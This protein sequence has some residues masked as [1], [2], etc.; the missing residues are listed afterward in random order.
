MIG[1]PPR[2][3]PFPSTTLSRSGLLG[4]GSQRSGFGCRFLRP[5][6]DTSRSEE[7]TSELQSRVDISYAVFCLKQKSTRM[8]PVTS[9]YLVCRLLL[10]EKR[11]TSH[12]AVQRE[13]RV[14]YVYSV[15]FSVF[16]LFFFFLKNG[17][18]PEF[19]FFPPQ[20]PFPI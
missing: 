1:R 7:H 5:G 2:S 13:P 8:N 16:F 18:P 6:A 3:T 9:G 14:F 17:P 20:A 15:S 11:P 10:A 4:V 12:P 19:P